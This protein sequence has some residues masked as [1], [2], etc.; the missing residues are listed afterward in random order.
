MTGQSFDA[1]RDAIATAARHRWKLFLVE[2]IILT[3]LGLLAVGV[4]VF[5]SLLRRPR[6]A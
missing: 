4:P 2:G 5:A 6:W 3:I 1:A